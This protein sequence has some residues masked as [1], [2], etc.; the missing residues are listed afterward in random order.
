MFVFHDASWFLSRNIC[1]TLG[2]LR[3]A[4]SRLLWKYHRFHRP[5]GSVAFRQARNRRLSVVRSSSLNR[6]LL[7]AN[8]APK[9][10]TRAGARLDTRADQ[11]AHFSPLSCGGAEASRSPVL[12]PGR[13][14]LEEGCA[15]LLVEQG[16]LFN[17]FACVHDCL[18]IFGLPK[19]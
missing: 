18:L 12:A 10:D 8:I 7:G 3:C 16:P 11:A 4:R 17:K 9:M 15:G 2:R 14:G 1:R 5:A 13:N 6:F 19:H